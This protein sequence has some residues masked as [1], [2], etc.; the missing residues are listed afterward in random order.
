MYR[1]LLVDDDLI[2][3]RFLKEAL[4]WENEG[5]QIA[6]DVSDGIEAFNL[7]KYLNPDLILILSFVWAPARLSAAK[8]RL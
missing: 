5:F 8:R 7:Y 4:N 2:V 1:V 3:R 6:G